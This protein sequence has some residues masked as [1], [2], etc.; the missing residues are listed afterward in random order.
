VG[1]LA[2]AS[3]AVLVLFAVHLTLIGSLVLLAVAGA[4][5]AYQITVG[6][7]FTSWVP[8]EVRGSAFGVARTGLRVAQGVGVAAGGALAQGIGSA[9]G[10]IVIA[11][12]VGVLLAVP[13]A[14]AWHRQ[15]GVEPGG[16]HN[17]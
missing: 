5:G 16:T 8:N 2:T 4:T 9:R 1:V 10:A 7:T 6:A 11:G 14:L 15:Y 17:Q 12:L 3:V 13:A